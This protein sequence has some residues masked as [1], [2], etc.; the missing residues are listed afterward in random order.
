MARK[1]GFLAAEFSQR[2]NESYAALSHDQQRGADRVLLALTKQ[3]ATPGMRVKP[4]EP[5][6]Y[7]SEARINDGDRLVHRIEGAKLWVVDVVAHDDIARYAKKGP[8]VS[9]RRER[10]P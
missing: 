4:I 10:R 6:K 2:F 5:E 9:S 1:K 8:G 7:Y 3:E